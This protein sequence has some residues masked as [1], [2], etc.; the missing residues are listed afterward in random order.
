MRASVPLLLA[1]TVA[2]CMP[3]ASQAPTA[4][5]GE[6]EVAVVAGP[7]C[8]VE[9][10]PP[11]PACDPRPVAGA[12]VFVSPG[13]GRDILVGEAVTDD[14]GIARL[15]LVPGDYILA[16]DAVEGMLGMPQ[17]M[18]VTVAPRRTTIVTLSY[19]TGIR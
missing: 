11:D 2:A 13:D 10:V 12:R 14:E 8:P 16:G 17:P 5:A 6:L 3:A 9:T 19:D 15:S 4:E 1:L 7:V 18:A